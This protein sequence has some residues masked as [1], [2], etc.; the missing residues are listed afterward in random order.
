MVGLDRVTEVLVKK[1]KDRELSQQVISRR[2]SMLRE[3]QY[4]ADRSDERLLY[5]RA[6]GWSLQ[7]LE[8]LCGLNS[9]YRIV[10]GPLASSANE[11][12]GK[13]GTE[14]PILYGNLLRFDSSRNIEIQAARKMFMTALDHVPK[15]HRI[16]TAAH[17]E[18]M[19]YR[20]FQALKEE[21]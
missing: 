10:L 20:L 3:L 19:L 14:T 1:L 7:R 17:F 11:R 16:I 18:D 6:N 4:L 12:N 2:E 15:P 5:V 9:F 13:L 8:V 21:E